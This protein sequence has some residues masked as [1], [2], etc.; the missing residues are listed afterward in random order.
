MARLPTARE[1]RLLGRPKQAKN[2]GTDEWAA[3]VLADNYIEN[4][5]LRADVIS[6]E[7]EHA[8]R[9]RKKKPPT[10]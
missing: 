4:A 9:P 7:R 5:R 1:D 6:G 10:A 2:R 8:S 3:G